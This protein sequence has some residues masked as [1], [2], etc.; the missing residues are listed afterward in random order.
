MVTFGPDVPDSGG[1]MLD[2]WEIVSGPP[3]PTAAQP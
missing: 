3:F 1:G 2:G